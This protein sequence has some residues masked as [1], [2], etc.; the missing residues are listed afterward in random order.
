MTADDPVLISN[1]LGNTA[2][3]T[4]VKSGLI[5]WQRRV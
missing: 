1:D 5:V 2:T 4:P 3:M